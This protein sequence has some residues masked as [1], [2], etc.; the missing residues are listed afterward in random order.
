[1]KTK[2]NKTSLSFFLISCCFHAGIFVTLPQMP[3][4]K[5]QPKLQEKIIEVEYYPIPKV[6]VNAK[7]SKAKNADAYS[8]DTENAI[9]SSED[10]LNDEAMA[11]SKAQELAKHT[12]SQGMDLPAYTDMVQQMISFYLHKNIVLD[13]KKYKVKIVFTIA[14]NGS[15][16][17]V[18]IPYGYESNSQNFDLDVLNAVTLAS[19]FFPP[20]PACVTKSQQNFFVYIIK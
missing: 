7:N 9:A 4:L 19:S 11:D 1:M 5:D 8:A 13:N 16:L 10:S 15:L 2:K 14:K 18:N 17:N 20:L 3:T 6:M 12:Y